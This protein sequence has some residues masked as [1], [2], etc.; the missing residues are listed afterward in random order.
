MLCVTLTRSVPVSLSNKAL[1]FSWRLRRSA[2]FDHSS[3]SRDQPLVRTRVVK[4]PP[5]FGLKVFK[6]VR[7]FVLRKSFK[8]SFQILQKKNYLLGQFLHI[9]VTGSKDEFI[10]NRFEKIK[11]K[12]NIFLSTLHQ[13]GVCPVPDLSPGVPHLPGLE[14]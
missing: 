10:Q 5:P 11:K 8:K 2:Q 9:S 4:G 12:N 3:G 7:S 14:P 1:K 6:G 13:P